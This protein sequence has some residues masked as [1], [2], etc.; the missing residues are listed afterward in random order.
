M[1]VRF[2]SLE[3]FET[4][5]IIRQLCNKATNRWKKKV[6]SKNYVYGLH[7]VFYSCALALAKSSIHSAQ[8]FENLETAANGTEI[9]PEKF[10]ENPKAVEIPKCQPFKKKIPAVN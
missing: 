4:G 8:T 10:A 2:F 7:L 6:L 9:S 1:Q 5:D 3:T